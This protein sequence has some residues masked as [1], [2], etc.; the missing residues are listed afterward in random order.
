MNS[1]TARSVQTIEQIDLLGMLCKKNTDRIAMPF[2]K[3][4]EFS[5]SLYPLFTHIENIILQFITPNRTWLIA[6]NQETIR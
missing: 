2:T 6:T 1:S 5:F 3:S 4:T